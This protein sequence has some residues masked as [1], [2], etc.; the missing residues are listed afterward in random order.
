M[1]IIHVADPHL[2]PP[3]E[4]LFG[5]DP[6]A[7]LSAAIA[8]INAFHRDA[9]LVFIAGDLVNDGK[10]ASYAALAHALGTLKPPCRLLMGNHDERS[11][12]R[13]AFP[14]HPVDAAGFVQSVCETPE[15]AFVLLDTLD[16]GHD[17]GRLC[18]A[19][20]DWLKGALR[21]LAGRSVF[22]AMHHP[23]A[24]IGV[25][26]LDRI[27]LVDEEAFAE[28]IAHSG[29]NIRHIFCG[30]VHCLTHGA[31][32]GIPFSAQRSLIHQFEA[33]LA[34]LDERIV[35][36][37]EQPAYSIAVIEPR[38]I[39]IHVREFLDKSPRFSLAN[40]V[41]RRARSP[42]EVPKL[43]S[44]SGGLSGWPTPNA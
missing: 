34:P 23:P 22:L 20:L 8:D 42:S 30:H 3:G 4:R 10:P 36:S 12:F 17:S 43:A 21:A 44:R 31:W 16:P 40:P 25:P 26:V 18:Q 11:A 38:S 13:A 35:G 39:A 9:A 15:G 19:R 6:N 27:A 5:L 14:D 29:V 1:K 24:P 41:A 2:T 32:R 7:R 28:V 37:Y 33:P